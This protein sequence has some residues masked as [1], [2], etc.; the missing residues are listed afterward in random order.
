M[1]V[2]VCVHFTNAFISCQN[3]NIPHPWPTV[4]NLSMPFV[5]RT[6]DAYVYTQVNQNFLDIKWLD[7]VRY[8]IRNYGNRRRTLVILWQQKY[9]LVV[10]ISEFAHGGCLYCHL[11]PLPLITNDG[12]Y[13]RMALFLCIMENY[14]NS[15]FRIVLS[16]LCGRPSVGQ[17]TWPHIGSLMPSCMVFRCVKHN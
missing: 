9:V 6:I 16:L 3:R 8:S 13:C 4:W 10:E 12:K 5:L 1:C 11:Q 15:Q 7:L 2:C 17:A 14:Q